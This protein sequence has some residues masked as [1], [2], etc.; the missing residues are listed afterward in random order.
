MCLEE[1]DLMNYVLGRD[2]DREIRAHIHSCSACRK[3]LARIEDSLLAEA[4]EKETHAFRPVSL[5]PRKRSA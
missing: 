2:M 1:K 5:R 4:L 3:Q